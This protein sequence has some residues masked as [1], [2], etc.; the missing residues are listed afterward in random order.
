MGCDIHSYAEV[1][2]E[3]G[4]W[5]QVTDF[6]PFDK[7]E[8]DW[9]KRKCGDS[10]FDWRS[11]SLFG[12]LADVRNYSCCPPLD[13]PRGLPDDVSDAVREAREAYGI[14]GH[15]DSWFLLRELLAFDYDQKFWN[16]RVTKQIGPNPWSGA[17]LAEEGEG[18]VIT[19]RE[20]LGEAY[21]T[22]LDILRRLD[23]P[24][25]VRVVFWFDN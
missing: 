10:P 20:H 7:W 13:E 9:R 18:E 5:E 23:D 17:A 19:Y 12:F 16:R 4:E 3:Q 21:F 2:N 25:K 1:Q 14:D 8:R 15:S 6:F 22:Q 24:E 11:Y